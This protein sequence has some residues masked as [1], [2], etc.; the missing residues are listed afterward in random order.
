MFSIIIPLY[1]K[2]SRIEITIKSVLAQTC[3]D[4]QIVVVDDG[5]TDN[6]IKVVNN[7]LDSRLR[8]ISQQNGGPS[9]ARN[10]GIDNSS[11]EW[12]LF[13]DADDE[14]LPNA[15][16]I[17]LD[18]IQKYPNEKC[19]ACNFYMVYRNRHKLYSLFYKEK[20]MKRPLWAWAFHSLF[21]R[22]G[23]F[24]IHRSVADKY[25]FRNNLRRYEDAEWL[26]RIMDDYSFVRNPLPV[27]LYNLGSTEASKRRNNITEDYLGNLDFNTKSYGKKLALFQFFLQ[28]KKIYPDETRKLYYKQLSIIEYSIL[29]PLY[30]TS[31]FIGYFVRFSSRLYSIFNNINNSRK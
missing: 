9:K 28:A 4:F 1:N 31:L 16:L 7:I 24:V 26:F 13:L 21:P 6:S 14:L 17:F 11:G 27:M 15:L 18:L 12:I 3:Q 2:E 20:V 5:S 25:R 8:I 23:A 22:T 29:Y 19:F 30:T 10:A